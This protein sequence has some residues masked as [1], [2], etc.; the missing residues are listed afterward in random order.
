[1]RARIILSLLLT[2]QLML[3]APGCIDL[4]LDGIVGPELKP[5]VGTLLVSCEVLHAAVLYR[6][7]TDHWPETSVELRDFCGQDD[8][9]C[10]DVNWS[11]IQHASFHSL[12]SDGVRMDIVMG[13]GMQHVILDLHGPVSSDDWDNPI[14]FRLETEDMIAEFAFGGTGG[15]E[16]FGFIEQEEK[17]KV[18][19]NGDNVVSYRYGEELTKPILWPVRT[20][21]GIVVTRGFPFEKVEGESTD[22]PHHTGVFFTYDKVNADGFWNNTTSPPQIRQIGPV[23]MET[24]AGQGMLS[25]LLHWVGK[26]GKVL[27][28]EKRDMLFRAGTDEYSIDFTIK[29]T[30]QD[31]KIVFEDTKEGMFGIRVADWLKE[32]GGTGEY[33]SSNGDRKEAGVW[34]KRAEWVRLEGKKDDKVIGIAIFNYPDSV[35]FPTYWHARGYGLFSANPLGQLDFQKGRNVEDP[36]PLNFTLAPGESAVFKFRMLIYEGPRSAEQ[37][38]ERYAEYAE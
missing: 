7:K 1:M 4:S 5:V 9:N 26:S 24:E 33:L 36:Q 8:A 29:L 19:I 37:L 2:G 15:D 32:D 31:E 17:I 14:D 20:P 16:Y 12:P 35:N 11:A 27:L 21:S 28:E 3:T 25:V 6:D 18:L 10:A 23:K 22:H 34:G 38:E 13:Q 30:A